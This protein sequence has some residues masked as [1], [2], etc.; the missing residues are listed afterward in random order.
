MAKIPFAKGNKLST[1][2]PK[3]TVNK[4]T[5]T[6]KQAFEDA[7]AALQKHPN[8]NLITWGSTHPT[9]FYALSQKLIP[10]K[11]EAAVEDVTKRNVMKLPDGTEIEF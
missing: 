6:V 9:Q 7:F 8:A 2:R 5:Q 11:I 3:G 4:L 1:G 10:T